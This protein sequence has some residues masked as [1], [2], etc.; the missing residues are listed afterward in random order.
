M[1]KIYTLQFKRH[2]LY[3]W[4]EYGSIP[5]AAAY[6][7]I[8]QRTLRDWVNIEYP[9]NAHLFPRRD[10]SLAYSTSK[11]H[12]L[13][14][15]VIIRDSIMEAARHLSENLPNDPQKAYY[16]SLTVERYLDQIRKI[17]DALGIEPPSFRHPTAA[18]P[19][20]PAETADTPNLQPN[21]H[22]ASVNE[23]GGK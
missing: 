12:S 13:K 7:N 19:P 9:R 17:N 4:R 16:A 14:S 23:I 10:E 11:H 20:L 6:L 8:P 15:L 5:A 2:A 1:P 18:I 21:N 3:I 22:G